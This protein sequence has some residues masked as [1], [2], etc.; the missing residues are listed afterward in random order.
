[1]TNQVIEQLLAESATPCISVV[2]P[3]HRTAPDKIKDLD[4]VTSAVNLAKNL[5]TSNYSESSYDTNTLISKIDELVET[6]DF[7]HPQDGIGIFVS[8]NI[9]KLI[10]F[11]FPVKEKVKVSHAFE[12]MDLVYYLNTIIDYGVLAI[13]QKKINLFLAKGEELSEINNQDFPLVYE[14]TYEYSKPT[15]GTSYSNS[16]LKGFERDKS[17]IEE[18]RLKDLLRK[19]DHLLEKYINGKTP[20]VVSGGKKEISDYTQVT[21][22]EKQIIGKVTGSYNN[23]ELQLAK[24]AWAAVKDYQKS[25]NQIILSFLHELFGRELVAA[26]IEDVWKQANEG[27]GLELYISKDFECSAYISNDGYDLKL[28]P[29]SATHQYTYSVDVIERLINTVRDKR[30]KVVFLEKEQLA[31]FDDIALQMR[32]NNQP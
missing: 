12:R 28:Q 30:G 26:G 14:E 29:P 18:I 16:S 17:E 21:K 5:L 2:V 11:P 19:A 6:I 13:S 22:F 3:T 8:P 1:M 15:K 7:V 32:Y 20:L 4:A 23:A 24:L 27:K 31:D 9:S 10:T 25:Q